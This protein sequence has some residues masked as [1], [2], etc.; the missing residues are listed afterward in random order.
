MAKRY[1]DQLLTK[2]DH[3]YHTHWWFPKYPFGWL[4]CG[5]H[6]YMIG[7][8][9][10][11]AF[12]P[13]LY[14]KYIQPRV[15]GLVQHLMEYSRYKLEDYTPVKLARGPNCMACKNVIER[16]SGWD[17]I[18]KSENNT[19]IRAYKHV[20]CEVPEGYSMRRSWEER[21]A[22]LQRMIDEGEVG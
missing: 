8:P 5:L 1:E 9:L 21:Q 20:D 13:R 18:G 10:G 12:F 16:E 3:A 4:V 19:H 22:D 11:H 7:C 2:L 14:P 6:D 15:S 17:I